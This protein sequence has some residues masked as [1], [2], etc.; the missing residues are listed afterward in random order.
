MFLRALII[1]ALT[2]ATASLAPV[3][4][5]HAAEIKVLASVALTAVLNELAPE[6]EKSSGN[7]VTVGYGLAAELKA[8]VLNGE[9][10][11][12][13]ILTRPMMDELE[14]QKKVGA[15]SVVNVAGT[16]VSL[17]TRKGAP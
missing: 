12:I 1:A 7:K 15:N 6:F 11:D 9:S 17:T 8:R 2:T 16:P 10:V 5:V 3:P 4:S 14:Q 13:I